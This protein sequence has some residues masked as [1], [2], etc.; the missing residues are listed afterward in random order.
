MLVAVPGYLSTFSK[1]PSLVTNRDYYK[2]GEVD[3]FMLVGKIALWFSMIFGFPVSYN[4]FRNSI[5]HF[6]MGHTNFS[7]KA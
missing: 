1:T 2:E 3:Y 5:Y 4:P 7:N 6:F